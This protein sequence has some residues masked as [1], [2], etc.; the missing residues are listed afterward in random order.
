MGIDKEK[1][2]LY[3]SFICSD[4]M[5]VH[6]FS[7]CCTRWDSLRD[8]DSAYEDGVQEIRFMKSEFVFLDIITAFLVLHEIKHRRII[9][10]EGVGFAP[11]GSCVIV[12]DFRR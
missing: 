6:D 11:R 10:R 3:N 12:C 1:I 8:E 5:W 2:L 7:L 9:F 4:E